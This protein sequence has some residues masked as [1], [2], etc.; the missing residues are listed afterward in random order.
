MD[1]CLCPCI[2]PNTLL[3]SLGPRELTVGSLYPH[4]TTII[5][6]VM[7]NLFAERKIE[8]NLVAVYFAPSNTVGPKG[9]VLNGEMTFGGT[10][11]IRYTG[12]INYL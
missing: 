12:N 9:F 4:D 7:D 3:Y 1:L 11:S 2:A 10:N 8:Q 6:T 5:P